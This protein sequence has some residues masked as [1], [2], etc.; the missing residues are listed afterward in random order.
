MLMKDFVWYRDPSQT[1]WE[2]RREEAPMALSAYASEMGEAGTY[3][4]NTSMYMTPRKPER[5]LRRGGELQAYR[6]IDTYGKLLVDQFSRIATPANLLEFVQKFGP[7]TNEGR[8]PG[9]GDDVWHII[10]HAQQIRSLIDAY[11]PDQMKSISKKLGPKGIPLGDGPVGDIQARLVFDPVAEA[12]RLQL[13]PKNLLNA[14]WLQFA[15][16]LEGAPDLG[17]CNH[18]GTHFKRGPGTGRRADARYCSEEHQIA[19]NSMKRS[20]PQKQ[21]SRRRR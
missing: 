13:M 3:V 2:L 10:P 6:P 8:D 11:R 15:E 20:R 4:A 14:I 17:V 18:C 16:D 21:K 1:G 12:P 5:I 9:R 19:F 7:L